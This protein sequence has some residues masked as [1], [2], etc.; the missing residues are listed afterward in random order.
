MLKSDRQFGIEIEFLCNSIDTLEYLNDRDI[1]C[2]SDGSLRPHTGGEYVSPPMSGRSGEREIARVCSELKSNGVDVEH[3]ATSLHLHLDGKRR[4]RTVT[5][6][7]KKIDGEGLQIAVSRSLLRDRSLSQIAN[8]LMSH[9]SSD[10]ICNVAEFDGIEYYSR[11]KLSR[12]PRMNYT[13][14]LLKEND[15]T[16]WLTNMFYFYTLYSPVLSSMV[17]HSRSIGNMYCQQLSDSFTL[18]EIESIKT[19]QD[20]T[21]IWYKGRGSG[22]RYCDSRY[23]NVNF[24]SFF[25]RH[26]TVEIRSHGA[27]TDVN[28]IMLWVRLHQYIAD[29]LED[30]KLEDLKIDTDNADNVYLEFVKFFEDDPLLVEYIKRLLGYFSGISIIKNKVKRK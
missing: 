22:G 11:A 14:F 19:E 7:N 9:R 24:H 1:Y 27:T 23:H 17:S 16:K 13:F 26:G 30:Y 12:K 10:L 6:D 29:K 5:T 4:E 2:V 3:P 8:S 15:R 21:D 20:F 18:K 28:K 25:D